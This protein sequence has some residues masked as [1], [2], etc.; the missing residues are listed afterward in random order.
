MGDKHQKMRE[1]SVSNCLLVCPFVTLIAVVLLYADEP[2]PVHH[3]ETIEGERFVVTYGIQGTVAPSDSVKLNDSTIPFPKRLQLLTGDIVVSTDLEYLASTTEKRAWSNTPRRIQYFR[4][5]GTREYIEHIRRDASIRKIDSCD[6]SGTVFAT[7]R[8]PIVNARF[9][10]DDYQAGV[11]PPYFVDL[12]VPTGLTV[13]G[14]TVHA[15]IPFKKSD[16]FGSRPQCIIA[17]EIGVRGAALRAGIS[18]FTYDEFFGGHNLD[19]SP[20]SLNTSLTY[21]WLER[22]YRTYTTREHALYHGFDIDCIVLLFHARIG[23]YHRIHPG[24]SDSWHAM[25][26][27]GL[28]PHTCYRII[29]RLF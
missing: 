24:R 6:M 3:T 5:N 8:F 23:A 21:T 19:G 16:H 7:G 14:A 29:K 27:L 28:S 4:P 9:L 26:S 12:A 15:D 20:V 25:I 2:R 13:S 10:F 22:E 18:P 11:T 1:R 17:G